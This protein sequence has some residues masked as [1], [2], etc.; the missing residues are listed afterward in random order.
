MRTALTALASFSLPM[1]ALAQSA[2]EPATEERTASEQGPQP[3]TGLSASLHSSTVAEVF[4][5]RVSTR[6][7]RHEISVNGELV[8][9][10]PAGQRSDAVSTAGTGVAARTDA[11]VVVDD[12]AG[13]PEPS[14]AVQEQ[15]PVPQDIDA[16]LTGVFD[17]IDGVPYERLERVSATLAD[18]ATA[19]AGE[20]F[21]G[22]SP[23]EGA[24]GTADEA[25]RRYRCGAEGK[26]D[27]RV[28]DA[29]KTQLILSACEIAD[30]VASGSIVMDTGAGLM[31][32]LAPL[33]IIDAEGTRARWQGAR[34]L[35]RASTVLSAGL[36]RSASIAEVTDAEGNITVAEQATVDFAVSG[37]NDGGLK[38]RLSAS[39]SVRAPWTGQQMVKIA[40][41]DEFTDLSADGYYQTGVL[42]IALPDGARITLDAATGDPGTYSATRSLGGT[43]ERQLRTWTDAERLPC[44]SAELSAAGCDLVADNAFGAGRG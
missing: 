23:V 27:I 31:M 16:L 43:V 32:N 20:A 33:E 11:D 19:R 9:T 18:I 2:V 5:D 28:Q 15:P 44:L 6:T 34:D 35:Y 29:F 3:P 10:R 37:S 38:H 4:R 24:D 30:T 36:E 7:L 1:L 17:V 26:L 22:F 21:P 13:G 39:F 8:A 14:S 12:I 40:T 25:I 41:V 42:E